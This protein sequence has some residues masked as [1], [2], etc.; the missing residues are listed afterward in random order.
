MSAARYRP[1]LPST[2]T[3]ITDP[4]E[5]CGYGFT[6]RAR[7]DH[8]GRARDR[9]P[10][11]F[12]DVTDLWG[13][14]G[15][16]AHLS[17]EIPGYL[18][19]APAELV[20]SVSLPISGEVDEVFSDGAAVLVT[21]AVCRACRGRGIG[22]NLVRT[23]IAQLH[24]QQVGVIEVIGAFGTA[25]VSDTDARDAGITLLPV[26]FWQAVGFQIV[27]PHP[28]TPTLRL[29]VASTVRWRPQLATAWRRIAHLVTQ[30]GPAQPAGFHRRN[31]PEASDSRLTPTA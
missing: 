4:C 17:G 21:L 25:G 28:M 9:L 12:A 7:T 23:A 22:K 29:D 2:L 10:Q 11:W 18:S 26:R 24:R 20:D 13:S 8:F 27:R 14:C 31:R 1:L 30:P 5:H 15:V 3:E 6:R 19:Y 16:S